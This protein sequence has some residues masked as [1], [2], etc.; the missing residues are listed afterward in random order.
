MISFRPVPSSG[1]GQIGAAMADKLNGELS[2]SNDNNNYNDEWLMYARVQVKHLL[3][4]HLLSLEAT[5]FDLQVMHAF[6]N[7]ALSSGKATRHIPVLFMSLR[8]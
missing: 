6:F 3:P 4:N 7:L 1:S 5:I 8:L 2:L